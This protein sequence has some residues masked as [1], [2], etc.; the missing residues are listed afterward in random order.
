LL[1]EFLLAARQL[2]ELLKRF[3]DVLISWLAEPAVC[4]VS[5]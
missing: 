4:A 2:I 5:Y 3:V 1:C